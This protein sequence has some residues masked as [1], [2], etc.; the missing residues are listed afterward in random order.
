VSGRSAGGVAACR[1]DL[2]AE[3]QIRAALRNALASETGR[4]VDNPTG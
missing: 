4:P 2:P 3:E 1:L